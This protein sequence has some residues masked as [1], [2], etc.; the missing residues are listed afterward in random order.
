M[1]LAEFR[2][3]YPTGCLITELLMVNDGQYVVRA[4]VSLDQQTVATGLAA[5]KTIEAAEDRARSR[6][7]AV[8]NPSQSEAVAEDGLGSSAGPSANSPLADAP[9]HMPEIRP[10]ATA[11][12]STATKAAEP[13]TE[14]VPAAL[15]APTEVSKPIADSAN[16]A[17]A[18]PENFGGSENFGGPEDFDPS[19]KP[20]DLSDII[21]QTDV[22]LSR[23]GW[24][25]ADGREHLEKTYG[26]RSRQQLTD[27]ELLSF[28]LHL[29]T[30]PTPSWDSGSS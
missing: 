2:N 20:V 22:E 1:A 14:Q 3:H 17:I 26:K 11:M 19:A 24:T 8:L 12:P 29:E 18:P 21:A 16:S 25:S 6:A 9:N 10:E 30:L 4:A 5:D 13:P 27:E 23:L 7:L 15:P 28:L